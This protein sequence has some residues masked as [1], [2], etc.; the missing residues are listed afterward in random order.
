MV[1]NLLASPSGNRVFFQGLKR[2]G[3][4]FFN[5]LAPTS[6]VKNLWS[7]ISIALYTFM[8]LSRLTVPCTFSYFINDFK[9]IRFVFPKYTL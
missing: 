1:F 8:S 5:S 4:E 3:R 6:E 2:P 7:Y 9:I